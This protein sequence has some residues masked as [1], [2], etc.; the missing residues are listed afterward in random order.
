VILI[1][2]MG[3]GKTSVGKV[4]AQRLGWSFYDLDE[5]IEGREQRSVAAI[6]EQSGEQAFREIETAALLALLERSEEGCVIALGGGAFVQTQNRKALEQ[7]GGITVLLEASVGELQRR[8]EA[9]GSV[10]P[11]ARDTARF[12][13]LFSARRQ[14]YDLA[15]FRV[16]TEG[17]EIDEVAAEVERTLGLAAGYDSGARS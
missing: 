2:F 4:L 17:K 12:E 14:A 10:R 11:L 3:A 9:A 1:G 16:D 6:F 15:R 13:Q 5:A 7:A 8:C